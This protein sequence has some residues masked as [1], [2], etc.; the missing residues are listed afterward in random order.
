[1]FLTG[2]ALPLS[3]W[4]DNATTFPHEIRVTNGENPTYIAE[5]GQLRSMKARTHV[6]F[7]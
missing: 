4:K 6:G 2:K 3:C 7:L 5:N 1:M